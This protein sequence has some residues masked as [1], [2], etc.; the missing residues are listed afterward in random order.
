[1]SSSFSAGRFANPTMSCFRC[2]SREAARLVSFILDAGMPDMD[3]FS[4]AEHIRQDPKLAG[5]T[6]MMLNDADIHRSTR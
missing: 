5:A 6:I 2:S 3:G 1:V 4:V